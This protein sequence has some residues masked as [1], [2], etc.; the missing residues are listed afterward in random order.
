MRRSE[1]G[2]SLVLVVFSILLLAILGSAMVQLMTVNSDS[3]ARE[4][5]SARA[6][7][8]AESGAQREISAIWQ[9]GGCAGQ[10][11]L[12]FPALAGCAD[13][14]VTC[15]VVTVNGSQYYTIVSEGS[16]GPAGDA[17]TRIIE[18]QARDIQV[19]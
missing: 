8:A 11:G 6:F 5:L 10:H 15:N 1:Q 19:P 17:A 7:M 2:L 13:T 12:S 3:V 9:G 16:C 18:V 14:Q 4:V